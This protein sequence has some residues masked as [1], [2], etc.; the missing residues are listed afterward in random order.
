M[1]LDL[2][3]LW[4]P[5]HWRRRPSDVV[6]AA[7]RAGPTAAAELAAPRN[8]D[9]EK[10]NDVGGLSSKARLHQAQLTVQSVD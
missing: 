3:R 9:D 5:D 8:H 10:M 7:R 2:R 1:V 6:A 4:A